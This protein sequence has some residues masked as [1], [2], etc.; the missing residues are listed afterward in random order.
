MNFSCVLS[1]YKGSY[2][3]SWRETIFKSLKAFWVSQESKRNLKSDLACEEGHSQWLTVSKCLG[4]R[5]EPAGR[6]NAQV[7]KI[8]PSLLPS[9][10]EGWAITAPWELILSPIFTA[11]H[12]LLVIAPGTENMYNK[13][14]TGWFYLSN[15]KPF[16]LEL[17]FYFNAHILFLY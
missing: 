12:P 8:S 10:G 14:L 2:N 16:Y 7:L 5:S 9:S 1:T 15:D 6:E 17:W 13:Y 4:R 11:V 3:F